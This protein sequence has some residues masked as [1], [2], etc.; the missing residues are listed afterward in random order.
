VLFEWIQRASRNAWQLP[1]L[2]GLLFGASYF[3]PLPLLDFLAFVPLLVRLEHVA[4]QPRGGGFVP[5]LL[6]GLTAY[7][8]GLHF[9]W[10]LLVFTWLSGLLYFLFAG[11]LGLRVGL[12]MMLLVWLRRRTR[13]SYALLLPMCW[14]SFEWLQTLG[15][16]RMTGDHVAHSLARHPFLIQFADLLGPYAVG[17]FMLVVNGLLYET[18]FAGRR[19]ACRRAALVLAGLLVLVLGYDSWAWFRPQPD[20]PEL[21]VALVQP[22]IAQL[23][24]MDPERTAD[25]QRRTLH[26]LTREAAR[27]RPDLIVWPESARPDP[28]FH[29]LDRPETY[30][31]PEVQALA[32]EVGT[33]LLVGVE[34]VRVRDPGDY[35]LFNGAIVVDAQGRLSPRWAAKR[36]LVPF[37]EALPFR[38]LFGS[39]VE[40]RGGEWQWVAGN[41]RPAPDSA[42][43]EVGDA[44]VGVLVCFEELF[45]E[46]TR[47]LR[48]DGA[49]FQVV[50]TND[51]WWGRTAFQ[52]YLVDALRLRAIESRTDIVRVA[53]TGISGFVDR[54]GRY[55]QLTPLF[56]PA[57]EVRDVQRSTTRTL[58][59]RIGDL[60]VGFVFQE[61]AA[62]EA[63]SSAAMTL[64]RP[65]SLAE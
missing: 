28:V 38:G 16:L 27:E 48:N 13:W 53:N 33:S 45:P 20:L 35:D 42:V 17:A 19:E 14:L 43:V 49:E 46:L 44:R 12:T 15:D 9:Y 5:G 58:Y 51:A 56:E 6:Y 29:W 24:K 22:D 34:Y 23:D 47:G 31:M 52:R 10:A 63:R 39:L 61:A 41:F 62:S 36:Y 64:L 4:A 11:A 65:R 55:H 37:V 40:G 25:A 59:D 32:R 26:E 54:R 30:A 50:I 57:V 2:S 1:L 3:S 60:F 18:L 7:L 8:I 21:R